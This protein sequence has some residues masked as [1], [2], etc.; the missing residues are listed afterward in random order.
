[1]AAPHT[2]EALC[3]P[4]THEAGTAQPPVELQVA[5]ISLPVPRLLL[6][7]KSESTQVPAQV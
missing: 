5:V 6:K 3:S 1:M 4:R 7:T 2:P